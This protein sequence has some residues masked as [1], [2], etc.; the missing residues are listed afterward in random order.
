MAKVMSTS[1]VQAAAAAAGLDWSK[2]IQLM[3]QQGIPFILALI[4][5]FRQQ[6]VM[7]GAGG[8]TDADQLAHLKVHFEAIGELADCGA[9]CCGD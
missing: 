6:P 4:A 8:G 7:M 2:L 3:Q 5:A 1:E 9:A